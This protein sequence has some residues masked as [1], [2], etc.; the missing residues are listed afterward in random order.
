MIFS[1]KQAH[2]FG[3]LLLLHLLLWWST[4]KPHFLLSCD[5]LAVRNDTSRTNKQQ[6]KKNLL[7]NIFLLLEKASSQGNVVWRYKY[8][9]LEHEESYSRVKS[10][11]LH[12]HTHDITYVIINYPNCIPVSVFFGKMCI[13]VSDTYRIRYSY[14][15]PCN[16]ECSTLFISNYKSFCFF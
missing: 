9:T 16:I 2:F 10:L 12:T 7:W 15:Y 5:V 14:R 4:L 8:C 13:R 11:L 3:Q 6:L 1:S